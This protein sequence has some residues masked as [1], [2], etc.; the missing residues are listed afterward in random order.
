MGGSRIHNIPLTIQS[1][2]IHFWIQFQARTAAS[3]HVGNFYL[4]PTVL[5]LRKRNSRLQSE[6]TIIRG[7]YAFYKNL[8]PQLRS[9][10]CRAV[11][12]V[13]AF[14]LVSD[15]LCHLKWPIFLVHES[16]SQRRYI[17]QVTSVKLSAKRFI[18]C[19]VTL[20]DHA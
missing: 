4:F 11:T 10:R 16:N 8:R 19:E 17:R 18:Q 5:D 6:K 3:Q 2:I 9:G 13:G 14:W 7:H 1:T 20:H 15:F 12:S